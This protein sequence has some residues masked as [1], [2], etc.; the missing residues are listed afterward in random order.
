M[1]LYT[2]WIEI[3]LFVWKFNLFYTLLMTNVTTFI[4][5]PVHDKLHEP[6]QVS[7]KQMVLPEENQLL[8]WS[9]WSKVVHLKLKAVLIKLLAIK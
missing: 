8:L 4:I 5:V 7:D 3:D 9:S 6:L 2:F 1:I